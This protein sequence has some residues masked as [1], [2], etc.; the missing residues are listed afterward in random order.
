[1]SQRSS[2]SSPLLDL[3]KSKIPVLEPSYLHFDPEDLEILP[4]KVEHPYFTDPQ[5]LPT[6]FLD[7][8][9]D[10]KDTDFLHQSSKGYRGVAP[11]PDLDFSFVNYSP[12]N[13]GEQRASTLSQIDL[14]DDK[15]NEILLNSMNFPTR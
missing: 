6:Y 2:R 8:T 13:I 9:G 12:L 14:I 4:K 7:D 11:G 5:P 1:M 10:S 3:P 15:V